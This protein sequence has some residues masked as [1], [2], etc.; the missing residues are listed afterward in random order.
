MASSESSKGRGASAGAGGAGQKQAEAD[1]G[2]GRAQ[3]GGQQSASGGGTR[4]GK[5]ARGEKG[6]HHLVENIMT[7]SP[8]ICTPGTTLFEAAQLMRDNDCGALPVVES[9]DRPLPVGIV[10]DRDLVVRGLADEAKFAELLIVDVMTA[11]PA[12]IR[13]NEPVDAAIEIMEAQKI[14]RLI[15]VNDDGLCTG[16]LA[17]AD[18]A[19]SGEERTTEMVEAV[20]EPGEGQR[21]QT[22]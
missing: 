12:T 8:A 21:P 15:V 4:G 10:T 13:G 17:Q 5:G 7:A 1:K 11:E 6:G 14:R 2:A 3:Q 16:M 20:S 22:W 9:L 18:L 19:R